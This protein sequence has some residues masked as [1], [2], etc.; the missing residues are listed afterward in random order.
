MPFR[1]KN[2]GKG[3]WINFQKS[4]S[5]K[6]APLRPSENSPVAARISVVS[7]ALFALL[8]ICSS[9]LVEGQRSFF[10]SLKAI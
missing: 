6:N 4:K 5:R 7:H 2:R 9:L 1:E 3:W 10:N 8:L